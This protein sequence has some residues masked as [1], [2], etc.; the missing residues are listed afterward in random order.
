MEQATQPLDLPIAHTDIVYDK[1]S[2]ASVATQKPPCSMCAECK[3]RAAAAAARTR[4]L[5][6]RNCDCCNCIK[7]EMECPSTQHH[8]DCN[9]GHKPDTS[10]RSKLQRK[11]KVQ[12]LHASTTPHASELP[13]V[14]LPASPSPPP[15]DERSIDD[16]VKFIEE[17]K[18]AEKNRSGGRRRQLSHKAV[19]SLAQ[20]REAVSPA[21]LPSGDANTTH[22]QCVD[23]IT[24]PPPSKGESL[25]DAAALYDDVGAASTLMM[26]LAELEKEIQG[27]AVDIIPPISAAANI[28]Q[29]PSTSS[30]MHVT[31]IHAT[32]N[33]SS[34]LRQKTP[35]HAQTLTMRAPLTRTLMDDADFDRRL[36]EFRA[37]CSQGVCA[38]R[39]KVAID[40]RQLLGGARFETRKSIRC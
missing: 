5:L 22:M 30:D 26:R 17:E 8:V 37:F 38:P 4:A 1:C 9:N 35:K 23:T 24:A 15:A 27:Y 14:S 7:A 33:Y 11:L 2:V 10:T 6:F 16:L 34:S 39:R 32:T 13:S 31:T 18:I 28:S 25:P 19:T 21:K 40:V 29:D 20:T 12:Q 36:E 3:Q